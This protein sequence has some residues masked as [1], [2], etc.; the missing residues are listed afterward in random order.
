MTYSITHNKLNA[1][2]ARI[3]YYFCMKYLSLKTTAKRD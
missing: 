2:F 1:A 3:L